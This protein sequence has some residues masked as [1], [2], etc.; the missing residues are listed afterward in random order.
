MRWLLALLLAI[1]SLIST[2]RVTLAGEHPPGPNIWFIPNGKMDYLNMWANNA[3]W[4]SAAKK[5]DVL[6]IVH[7]WLLTVPDSQILAVVNFAKSRHMKLDF[8]I[9]AVAKFPTQACGGSEGYTTPQTFPAE[10]AVLKRLN[11][12][13]DIMTMDEPVGFGHYLPSSSGGCTL[14]VP[15]LVAN[16]A[17]NVAPILAQYPDI[18]VYEIE[19]MPYVTNNSDWRD[20]LGGFE[21]GLS[22]A[23]GRPVLGLTLDIDW[24]TPAWKQPLEDLRTFTSERN[25][26]LGWYYDGNPY[27]RSNAE[28][29]QRS[30]QSYEY[31]EGTM[32]II[33]DVAVFASWNTYP[34]Y[35]MPETDPT[36]QTWLIDDYFRERTQVQAQF[37]G[38][39]VHGQLTTK[40]GKPIANATINGYVPGVDFSIPLPATVVQ[41]VAPATA[42]FGLIGW[43]LNSECNCNGENDVLVGNLQYQETSGGSLSYSYMFPLGHLIFNGAIADNEWVGGTLVTRVIAAPGQSFPPNSSVFQVTGGAH[44]TFTIPASTIGGEGWYGHVFII[45]F[46]KNMNG[47]PGITIVPDAGHRLM[48]TTTTGAD[49]TFAL[50]SLPRVGPGAAPV[51]VEFPGDSTRRASAW[52]PLPP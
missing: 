46:D 41:D 40:L 8:E 51:T 26:R 34:V 37:V 25:M 35:N 5:V 29:I 16:V 45:F 9:E 3:P 22:Q 6:G 33:P 4:Q 27:A 18:Q 14:S 24:G 39:G 32:G 36:A 52:T 30:V 44:F 50:R 1:S 49:G 7:W 2:E 42:A 21:T 12:H 43:R 28:W 23:L 13:M 48:S 15:D 10:L 31:I 20:T 17:Q 47:L 38:A 11:I 19:P